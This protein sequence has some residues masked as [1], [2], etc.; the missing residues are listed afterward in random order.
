MSN[1]LAYAVPTQKFAD[2]EAWRFINNLRKNPP[3][4]ENELRVIISQLRLFN[5][6]LFEEILLNCCKKF[7]YCVLPK[8]GFTKDNG[9]D[10]CF[11]YL[12]RF[13]VVQAKL[14]GA[15]ANPEHILHLVEASKWHHAAKGFLFHTGKASEDFRKA[16]ALAENVDIVS[17]QK[18][19]DF[20][21]GRKGLYVYGA[22]PP[23]ARTNDVQPEMSGAIA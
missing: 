3:P 18:L 10:G 8:K 5:P 9:I 4:P 23:K 17:G 2:S 19:I 22:Y 1:K 12:G 6:F 20:L 21:L 13:Y 15:E 11:S 7:G 14:Y 16:A